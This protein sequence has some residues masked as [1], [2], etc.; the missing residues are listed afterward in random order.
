MSSSKSDFSES[1][2]RARDDLSIHAEDTEKMRTLL[3]SLENHLRNE[4]TVN[5][6]FTVQ[7]FRAGSYGRQLMTTRSHEFDVIV[8]LTPQGAWKPLQPDFGNSNESGAGVRL[9]VTYGS[10]VTSSSSIYPQDLLYPCLEPQPSPSHAVCW[11]LRDRFLERM[12]EQLRF[13]L[14]KQGWKVHNLQGPSIPVSRAVCLAERDDTP[15]F[16]DIILAMHFAVPNAE[17]ERISRVFQSCLSPIDYLRIFRVASSPLDRW[18]DKEHL[19]AKKRAPESQDMVLWKRSYSHAERHLFKHLDQD[20]DGCRKDCI[21]V[22]KY[23]CSKKQINIKSYVLYCLVLDVMKATD[24]TFWR[25]ANIEACMRR[26]I[27]RMQELLRQRE[28]KFADALFPSIDLLHHFT[29]DRRTEYAA[30]LGE[31]VA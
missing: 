1:I 13:G 23:M 3:K 5:N 28:G 4:C 12:K 2:K 19:I 24:A 8:Q 20:T 7:T 16:V 18:F 30:K 25:A 9:N 31:L 6:L 21:R 14:E 11:L 29:H 26:C 17:R 22:L 15:I 10:S 27:S